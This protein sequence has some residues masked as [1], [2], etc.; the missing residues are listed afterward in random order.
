[1]DASPL[2]PSPISSPKAKE[3]AFIVRDVVIAKSAFVRKESRAS[4]RGSSLSR[5]LQKLGSKKVKIDLFLFH[6]M[7]VKEIKVYHMAYNV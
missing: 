7:L 3:K 6:L 2:Q 4:K 5:G 1:M